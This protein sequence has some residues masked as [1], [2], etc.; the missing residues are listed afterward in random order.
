[1]GKLQITKHKKTTND[2]PQ[3]TNRRRFGI[4]NLPPL[5]GLA[6][7][8]EF[9]ISQRGFG[10]VEVIVGI[11]LLGVFLLGFVE[12][13]K[14]A[15]RLI[16]DSSMRLK[17]V[18]LA[19]EG[20]EAMRGMRDTGWTANIASVP[21]DTDRWL[22]F[23]G[24]KWILSAATAPFVDGRFD[25]RVRVSSVNRDGSDDIVLVGGSS[26]AGTRKLT[27]DVSWRVREATTTISF[28]TYLTNL[29]DN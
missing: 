12:G 5:A 15:F 8:G 4:W 6:P 11:A 14:I 20:M 26:D 19:E 25:R 28:L 17:G 10:M 9:G 29:F 23:D 3:I 13:G 1:M 7:G 24:T 21:L 27:V 16:D 22:F 2:K 18:F